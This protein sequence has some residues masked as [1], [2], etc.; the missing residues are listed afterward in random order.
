MINKSLPEEVPEMHRGGPASCI[1][2]AEKEEIFFLIFLK[3]RFL[4]SY[5]N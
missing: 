5:I 4:A 1:H 3:V 2:S